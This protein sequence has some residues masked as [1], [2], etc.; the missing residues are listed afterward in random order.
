MLLSPVSIFGV[1]HPIEVRGV[2]LSPSVSTLTGGIC[3]FSIVFSTHT[4]SI[5]FSNFRIV[6]SKKLPRLMLTE[7]LKCKWRTI[8]LRKSGLR[9]RA[10]NLC[11]QARECHWK[12]TRANQTSNPETT[13]RMIQHAQLV[14]RPNKKKSASPYFSFGF[15]SSSPTNFPSS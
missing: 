15:K 5:S 13:N 1:L 7:T 12:I 4:G 9:E 8:R 14:C 10:E 3:P 6:R 11:M 2:N